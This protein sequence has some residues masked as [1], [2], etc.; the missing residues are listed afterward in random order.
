MK[1]QKI[2]LPTREVLHKRWP[3]EPTFFPNAENESS[4]TFDNLWQKA[5]TVVEGCNG[6]EKGLAP[7]CDGYKKEEKK[8]NN[9]RGKHRREVLFPNILSVFPLYLQQMVE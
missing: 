5:I 8:K 9:H 1:I 3:L 6:I 2:N 7:S 4:T